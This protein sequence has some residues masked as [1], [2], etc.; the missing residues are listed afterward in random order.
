MVKTGAPAIDCLNAVGCSVTFATDSH[1]LT[2][3]DLLQRLCYQDAVIASLESYSPEVLAAPPAA[4]LKMISRWGVGFDAVNLPAATANGILVTNT[5]GLLDE[6]VADYTLALLLALARRIPEGQRALL[7]NQWSGHWGIDVAGKTLGLVGC[8]RIALA[9]AR[10]AAGFGLRLLASDPT[11]TEAARALGI[12]FV[13]LETLL[14][15]SDFVSL[16]AALTSQ[17]RG[18]IGEVQLRAMKRSALLINAGRGALLDEAALV[19]ALQARW[20][21]GAALDVFCEEPLS[22]D[23]PFRTTPN[24]LLTPHQ[25]S[26]AFDTG[27]R[28]SHTAA[29]AILDAMQGRRPRFLLNPEVLNSPQCRVTLHD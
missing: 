24:L 20:I 26:F 15:E 5:P 1:P 23:H 2:A 27:A 29:Q 9:V 18:L 22:P 21:A 14:A 11:P 7:A 25:A 3:N 16:H 8:G 19:R 12:R 17:T 13:S 28:V 6:A 4:F 10:R